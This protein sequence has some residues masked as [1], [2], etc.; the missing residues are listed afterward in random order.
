MFL[1]K[2]LVTNGITQSIVQFYLRLIKNYA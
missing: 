2:A 1:K